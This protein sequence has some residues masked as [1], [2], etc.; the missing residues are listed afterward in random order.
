M[1]QSF[2]VQFVTHEAVALNSSTLAPTPTLYQL[3]NEKQVCAY[4]NVSKRN[5]YCW[6]MAGLI[7][8]LKIGRAVRYRPADVEAALNRMSAIYK[9]QP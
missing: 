9:I 2:T 8:Y 6:R 1:K 5:L 3:M 4:L 7:P